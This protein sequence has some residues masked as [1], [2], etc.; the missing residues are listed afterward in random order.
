M[1]PGVLSNF[2]RA[3]DRGRDIGKH[4]A[5]AFERLRI[6][7]EEVEI[8]GRAMSEVKARERGAAGQHVAAFALEERVDDLPLECS[9]RA[10]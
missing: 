6:A 9:E 8:V 10:S 2:E 7:R 4:E 1:N 3:S 5:T